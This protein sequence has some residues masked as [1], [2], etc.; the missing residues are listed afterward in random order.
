MKPTSLIL[1][2]YNFALIYMSLIPGERLE[3]YPGVALIELHRGFYVHLAAYFLLT[4]F[5]RVY[6]VGKEDAF[7]A[8][9]MTGAMLEALQG[10]IPNRFTSISDL[11][12]NILGAL[13]GY[14]LLKMT[15][16]TLFPSMR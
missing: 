6:G 5:W 16:K 7:V 9:S 13:G 3:A 15:S 11:A 4:V 12:A 2:T 1:L 10:I 8:S 14:L